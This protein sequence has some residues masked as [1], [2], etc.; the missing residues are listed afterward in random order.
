MFDKLAFI[1]DTLNELFP[2]PEIPLR[3]EDH[4]T[5]LIAVLLSARCTDARVNTITPVLFA[6]AKT[7]EQML[8]LGQEE[9]RS[10]IR[11][12][13]LSQ[14]KSQAIIGLSEQLLRLHGGQVPSDLQALEALPG[15]GNKTARVVLSQAFGIPSFPVDTHIARMM[16]RWKIAR[17]GQVEQIQKAAMQFFPR[18][19]WNLLHLQIIYY[20]RT[21]SPARAY[22]LE[23]DVITR[24]ILAHEGER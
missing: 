11:P 23:K 14:S 6:R 24:T 17:S 2:D 1:I 15:V 13:G 20:A 10:I 12:C 5:L 3:H 16:K 21:Y 8:T 18:E 7:P 4:F 9:I 19:L 22:D